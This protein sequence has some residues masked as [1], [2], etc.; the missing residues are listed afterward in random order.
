MAEGKQ[1]TGDDM[2]I[3][4]REVQLKTI[5]LWGGHMRIDVPV[6]FIDVSSKRQIPET[7]EVNN[8]T[9]EKEKVKSS[10]VTHFFFPSHHK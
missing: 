8:F 6:G 7:Q 9:A 5:Y 2:Q 10:I 4:M 1:N 3:Q